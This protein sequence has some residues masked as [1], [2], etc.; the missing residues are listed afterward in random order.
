MPGAILPMTAA[1]TMYILGA[2]PDCPGACP[3]Y[4]S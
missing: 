4:V 1:G 2:I 3:L